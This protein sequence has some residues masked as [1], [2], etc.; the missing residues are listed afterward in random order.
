MIAA[1]ALASWVA[2]TAAVLVAMATAVLAYLALGQMRASSRQSD[3]LN[4]QADAMAALAKTAAAQEFR[5][6]LS[7]RGTG[8]FGT[9]EEDMAI[10][11]KG[12]AYSLARAYPPDSRKDDAETTGAADPPGRDS[13]A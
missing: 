6:R 3:A 10:A 13:T 8:I 4:R 7:R 11:L 2:A 1:S 5:D 12:I 9:P